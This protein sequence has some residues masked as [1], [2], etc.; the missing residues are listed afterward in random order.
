[1]NASQS[2]HQKI[3]RVTLDED[4][5]LFCHPAAVSIPSPFSIDP[6]LLAP[7]QDGSQP[8]LLVDQQRSGI[9]LTTVQEFRDTSLVVVTP[10]EAG[11]DIEPGDKMRVL[12]PVSSRQ[13]YVLLTQ[14]EQVATE[15][16]TLRYRYPRRDVRWAFP[17]PISVLC[18]LAPPVVVAALSYTE[19]VREISALPTQRVE[20]LTDSLREGN[21]LRV[22]PMMQALDE[23]PTV[24]CTLKDISRGGM[25]VIFNRLSNAEA[26]EQRLVRLQLDITPLEG[27]A[28]NLRLEPLGVIRKVTTIDSGWRAHIE[29]LSP[30]PEALNVTLHALV[31]ETV[32]ALTPAADTHSVDLDSD[33]LPTS[34]AL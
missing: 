12:F 13:H 33:P 29:F 11:L 24:E 30:L 17:L 8:V 20:R 32:H 1:M 21:P 27:T 14:A 5:R 26:Y 23:A 34:P 6:E 4:V 19:V 10:Q 22:S 25:A 9:R 16:I 7:F 28:S 3:T 18:T 2:N 31:H 15:T